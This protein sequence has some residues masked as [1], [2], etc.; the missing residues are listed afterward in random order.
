MSDKIEIT[1]PRCKFQWKQSLQELEKLETIY[2]TADAKP[3]LEK[4][5]ARCPQDGTYI[6]IEITE[7]GKHG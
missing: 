7:E 4:Y 3:G 6:V 5:R 2:K 1:C